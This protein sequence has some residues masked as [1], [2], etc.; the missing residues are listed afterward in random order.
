MNADGPPVPL[1]ADAVEMLNWAFHELA[2]NAAKHGALSAQDGHVEVSRTLE[3]SATGTRLRWRNPL[4]IFR[5]PH[6]TA[7]TC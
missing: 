3:R 5:I 4:D 1:A 6:I 2:T 7:P